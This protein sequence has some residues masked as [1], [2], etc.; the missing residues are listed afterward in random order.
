MSA[1]IADGAVHLDEVRLISIFLSYVIRIDDDALTIEA[2]IRLLT[3][4]SHLLSHEL[5][6]YR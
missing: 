1:A 4:D 2:H 6:I 5:S 3:D